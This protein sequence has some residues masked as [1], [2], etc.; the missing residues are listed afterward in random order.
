MLSRPAQRDGSWIANRTK[1][2]K[3]SPQSKRREVRPS[4]SS[5]D[6][7]AFCDEQGEADE[8]APQPRFSELDD[9]HRVVSPIR[10]FD[11]VPTPVGPTSPHESGPDVLSRG[12]SPAGDVGRLRPTS[13]PNSSRT[14]AVP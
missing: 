3:P 4:E 8:I 2:P 7:W 10:F 9:L 12:I 13:L 6:S 1:S 11:D 14:T 5:T